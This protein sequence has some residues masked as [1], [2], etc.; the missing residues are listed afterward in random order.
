[1]V[2][3]ITQELIAA[4]RF[5]LDAITIVLKQDEKRIEWPFIDELSIVKKMFGDDLKT[6]VLPIITHAEVSSLF[7]FN[8]LQARKNHPL[9]LLALYRKVTHTSGSLF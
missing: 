7:D 1:M 2:E 9:S 8:V 6:N 4:G 3:E 5:R